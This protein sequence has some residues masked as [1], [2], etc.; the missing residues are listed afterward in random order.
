MNPYNLG[1]PVYKEDQVLTIRNLQG[2]ISELVSTVEHSKPL[3]SVE[4]ERFDAAI[5]TLTNLLDWLLMGKPN[6]VPI[7]GDDLDA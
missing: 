4:A 1:P 3:T 5:A 2:I 6:N 7:E